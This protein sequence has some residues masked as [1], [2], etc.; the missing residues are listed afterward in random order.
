MKFLETNSNFSDF[1]TL[2]ELKKFLVYASN[3]DFSDVFIK[4]DM[5]IVVNSQGSKFRVTN[6]EL[7]VNEVYN[8]II[9]LYGGSNAISILNQ[10]I[11]LNNA[12]EFRVV[13][14]DEGGI[15]EKYRFRYNIIGCSQ[16][17]GDTYC[18]T[19]RRIPTNVPTVHD[20]DLE[21]EVIELC[22]YLKQGM[23]F[24]VGATSNGK[25]TTLAAMVKYML[26]KEDSG[27]NILTVED[28]IEFSHDY[29]DPRI[30][31]SIITQYAVGKNIPTFAAGIENMLRSAPTHALVGECKSY[32][33]IKECFIASKKGSVVFS[34]LH[35]NSA[36]ETYERLIA[37][38]PIEAQHTAKY[39]IVQNISGI[40]AQK[41]V[42]TTNG[43]RTSIREIF[44]PTQDDKDY[45]VAAENISK[46]ANERVKLHGKPIMSDAKSK[47][48]QGIISKAV[49]DELKFN[50]ER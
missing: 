14:Y 13:N 18:I 31:D 28:P 11:P 29:N 24:V 4:G 7:S 33:T 32:E 20:I 26:S 40:I 46:A 5:P 3:N 44:I 10:G 37:E 34:T 1:I 50:A 2:D 30:H 35:A 6:R 19:M 47:Y 49:Y 22:D 36:S 8:L 25:S 39:N 9:S 16:R 15:A 12:F 42:K 41:L 17:N 38:Y 48:E 21:P 45:I 43:K 23:V 27:F